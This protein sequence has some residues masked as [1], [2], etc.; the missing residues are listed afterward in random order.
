MRLVIVL[1]LLS[2]AAHAEK[3]PAPWWAF[4]VA[5]PLALPNHVLLHESSH[6]LAGLAVGFDIQGFHPYPHTNEGSLYLG[7]V[8]WESKQYPSKGQLLAF[9][10]APFVMD[11][12]LFAL[13][14]TLL[15]T[16]AVEHRS[17]AGVFLYTMGLLAP[18][19]DFAKG[20][21]MPDNFRYVDGHFHGSDWAVMRGQGRGTAWALNVVG[22]VAIAVGVWRF[23]QHSRRMF[24]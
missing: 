23:V 4:G 16:G 6:A 9:Y 18:L 5:A 3:K 2:S 1:L 17:V 22:A 10:G 14:D 20:Y 21:F 7:R 12:G 19:I 13:S 15:S 24:R 11:V 8:P